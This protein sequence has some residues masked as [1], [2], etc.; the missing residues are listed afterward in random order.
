MELATEKVRYDYIAVVEKT[1]CTD[2]IRGHYYE[3][4][5]SKH[6]DYKSIRKEFPRLIGMLCRCTKCGKITSSM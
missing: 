1:N 4:I 3:W 6:Q 5:D 2:K